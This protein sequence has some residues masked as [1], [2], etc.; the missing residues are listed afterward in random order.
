LT[1]SAQIDMLYNALLGRDADQA[2]HDYWMADLARGV[3]IET[4]A[5]G[6]ALSI[7]MQGLYQRPDGWEFLV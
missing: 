4:I 1:Q 5:E 7:E 2:G 3:S 6:F